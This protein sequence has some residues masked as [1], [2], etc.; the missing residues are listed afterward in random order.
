MHAPTQYYGQYLFIHFI[1][2][3]T[4]T[5]CCF[6]GGRYMQVVTLSRPSSRS[7]FANNFHLLY[8]FRALA[9]VHVVD[10]DIYQ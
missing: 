4:V 10:G 8:T 3:D 7:L 6:G 5:G 9:A 1:S 2:P